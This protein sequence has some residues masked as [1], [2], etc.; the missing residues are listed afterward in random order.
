MK[1]QEEFRRPAM[2]RALADAVAAAAGDRSYTFMEVCGSHTMALFRFGIRAMLPK[3]VTLISG[4]GC[5]VCI[6]GNEFM[7]YA[8]HYSRRPGVLIATFGDMF[9]VPG[10]YGA[11]LAKEKAGGADIRV[12]YSPLEA[13]NLAKRHPDKTVIFL[14]VGFETTAPAAAS[15]ILDAAAAGLDNFLVLVAHK[16]VPEALEALVNSPDLGLQ[17]FLCPGHVSVITGTAIYEPIVDKYGIPCVVTGFE[18]ADLLQSILQLIRQV[19]EG[20]ADVENAYA[21][22]VRPEGNPQAQ[23]LVFQVFDYA[24]V[25]WRGIGVIPHSGLIL[26][27]A[28][29]HYNALKRLP[30]EIPP[31]MEHPE[32][33]CGQ[34]LRGGKTPGDCTAFGG[35]CTPESPLGACMVSAEGACGAWYKYGERRTVAG[36]RPC[37]H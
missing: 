11:S 26:K 35:A 9:K 29:D 7:D 19:N 3:G 2:V 13:V 20:R 23:E 25:E 36:G 28:Y 34:V 21:R 18:P 31:V 8:I 4:P 6:T 17:G 10:S 27:P 16:T 1:F 12:I 30:I 33:I 32:C 22:S 37:L 5:P 24:D 15:A 14:A